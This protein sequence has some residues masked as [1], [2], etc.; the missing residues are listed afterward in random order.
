[1]YDEKRGSIS[2]IR[3]L[4]ESVLYMLTDKIYLQVFQDRANWLEMDPHLDHEKEKT[5]KI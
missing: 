1:M 5:E 3:I 2:P 4:E